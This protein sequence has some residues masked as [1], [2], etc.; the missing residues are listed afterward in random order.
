MFCPSQM[1]PASKTLTLLDSPRG[2]SLNASADVP[3]GFQNSYF[4]NIPY[5]GPF[6]SIIG[7]APKYGTI[8]EDCADFIATDLEKEDTRFVGHRVGV[9]D[10]GTAGK[11]K[12]E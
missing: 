7:N 8:L 3:P 9:I 4:H 1:T 5:L 11:G 12:S 10:A 2:N 6:L